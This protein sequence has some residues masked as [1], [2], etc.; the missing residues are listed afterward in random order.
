M[1]HKGVLT[2]LKFY[3]HDAWFVGG[4]VRDFLLGREC[5]DV[6]IATSATPDEVKS[7]FPGTE[8]VGAHFGV[9]LVKDEDG[10]VEVATYRKDG[11]YSDGRRP[12][13]VEFT[14]D[15]R[16]DLRRRDF[17]INAILMDEDGEMK[18]PMEGLHDLREG[19]IRCIGN[20]DDRF[21]EDGLRLMRAVRFAAQLNFTIE[22][23]TYNAMK[24]NAR[25]SFVSDERIADE[26]VKILTSG[27][28]AYGIRILCDTRLINHAVAGFTDMERFD[29]NPRHHA[30]GNVLTHTILLLKQLQRGCSPALALATLLHDIGKPETAGVSK[31]GW[32]NFHGHEEAGARITEE[33]LRN[34]RFPN[35]VVEQVTWMVANHMRFMVAKDMR[36]SKLLRWIRHP[37]F[38]EL[39]ELH[40]MDALAG[41]GNL[42]NYLFAYDV[43]CETP[44]EK[45]HGK[46]LINGDDLK[47]ICPRLAPGPRY[48]E[49]LDAVEDAQ[50]EGT[51][52]TREEALE[53]AVNLA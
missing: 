49:I 44:A 41:S 37:W 53:M 17:T 52:T 32:P 22:K 46:R 48:K 18:D 29:Q 21:R 14:K 40:R 10:T 24:F 36:K 28:A 25:L 38:P 11:Q 27:K 7:I 47:E 3:G 31:Y 33:T 4:C 26:L 8:M 23:Q 39:M 5:K 19:V 51:I 6:D 16:E 20:P 43:L 1:K 42:E 35:D 2:Q 15:V 50:L 30:E 12:D 45:L 9:C 34:L 13:Q